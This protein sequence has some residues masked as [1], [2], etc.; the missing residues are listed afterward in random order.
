M[1]DTPSTNPDDIL[2]QLVTGP[3]IREVAST[4]IRAALDTQYPQLHIDPNLAMV[5]TP[6]WTITDNQVLPGSSR[7]ESLTDALVRLV[8]SG[9]T[10]TYIDGE[11]F[12]TRQPGV[13][14]GIKLPVK[15]DAIGCLL[16]RLARLLFVAY[17][18]QQLDYWNEAIA[19]DKPRWHQYQRSPAQ[20]LERR[21]TRRLGRRPTGHGPDRLQ[22]PATGR[23]PGPRQVPDTRLPDRHRPGRS[24]AQRTSAADGHR[25]HCRHAGG[26]HAGRY[27][28]DHRGIQSVRLVGG[29]GRSHFASASL[30]RQMLDNCSGAFTNPRAIFSTSRPVR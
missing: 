10:A 8:L 20:P 24:T 16:N 13:E 17:Q 26:T 23:S 3:S 12:L 7:F 2:T 5:V 30:H 19:P 28:F 25:R 18:E 15:I 9:A 14:P 1:P 4:S 27:A 29:I 21:P 22:L 11:H 6:V